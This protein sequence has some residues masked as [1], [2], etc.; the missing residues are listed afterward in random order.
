MAILGTC[1]IHRACLSQ[2]KLLQ[3]IV[4][5]ERSLLRFFQ[6]RGN[7]KSIYIYTYVYVYICTGNCIYIYVYIYIYILTVASG[8]QNSSMLPKCPGH[9]MS[10]PIFDHRGSPESMVNPILL[11]PAL[12]SAVLIHFLNFSGCI[13]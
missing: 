10:H 6:N 5:Y 7:I 2:N 9:E 12:K 11:N 8:N 13:W 3:Y 1:H 4:V